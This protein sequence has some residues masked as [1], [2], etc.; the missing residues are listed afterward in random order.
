MVNNKTATLG[1][2]L[3]YDKNLS[4]NNTIS[5]ASCH[6]AAAGFN[7]PARF[8]TGFS[9]SAFSTAH[10]MRLGN[11]RFYRPGSMFWNK[12]TASVEL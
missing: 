5:C 12:R 6:Q 1:R 2:V 10:S 7:D 9:G 11:I 4:F 8:S 3:F